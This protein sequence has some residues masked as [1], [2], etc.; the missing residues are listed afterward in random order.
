MPILYNGGGCP[1]E[2]RN[3]VPQVINTPSQGTVNVVDTTA[4]QTLTGKT[5]TSPTIT[6]PTLSG[7][8]LSDIKVLAA[9]ATFTSTA[10]LA[11]LT[12]FSWSVSAGGVYVFDAMIPASMTINGGISL[13]FKYTTAT[14]TA[15]QV[16]GYISTAT[17][18]AA[19]VSVQ[20]TTTTDQTKFIDTKTAAY[21]YATLKGAIFVNAAGTIALQAAQNTSHSDTTTVKKGTYMSLIRVS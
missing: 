11:T 19:A 5:L 20:S 17:D 1:V 16:T 14:L 6:S 12:G 2:F 8:T 7:I 18:N 9:D 21:T 15:I 13:A 4:T 10:A 3:T